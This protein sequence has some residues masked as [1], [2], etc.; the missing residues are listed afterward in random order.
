MVKT[1]N[2][3]FPL[4]FCVVVGSGIKDSVF[5]IEKSGSGIEKSGSGIEKSGSGINIPDTQHCL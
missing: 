2:I 3:L 1:T 4:L 5:G